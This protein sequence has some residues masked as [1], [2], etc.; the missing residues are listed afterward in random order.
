MTPQF[1]VTVFYADNKIRHWNYDDMLAACDRARLFK[2]DRLV[3]KVELSVI[4]HT[5]R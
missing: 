4:I 1:I 2:G 5:W 3:H